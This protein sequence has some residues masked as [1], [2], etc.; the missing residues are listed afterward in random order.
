MSW[1]DLSADSLPVSIGRLCG[2]NENLLA[3]CREGDDDCGMPSLINEASAAEL[4]RALE[5]FLAEHPQA[6]VVED[7]RVLFEMCSSKYAL[8]AEYGRCVLHLW[9]EERNLVRTVAAVDAKKDR[10]S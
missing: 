2:K 6:A 8:S 5:G 10:K 9:S 3:S 1:R 4:T 7:G